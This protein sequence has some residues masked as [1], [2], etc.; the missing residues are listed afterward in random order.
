M[1]KRSY[2]YY[3]DALEY[4]KWRYPEARTKTI[5]V[6]CSSFNCPVEL[7][8]WSGEVSAIEVVDDDFNTIA[9]VAYWCSKEDTI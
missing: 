5:S 2:Y 7:D 4:I 1:E 8:S 6:G 9:V 3:E